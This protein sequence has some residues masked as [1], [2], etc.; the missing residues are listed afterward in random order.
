MTKTRPIFALL[1][2][3][4]FVPAF[5]AMNTPAHAQGYYDRGDYYDR[6]DGYRY[7][8][9]RWDD[10]NW[11]R[12]R[13]GPATYNP[14]TPGRSSGIDSNTRACDLPAYRMDPRCYDD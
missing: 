13:G 4:A 10:R 14:R 5:A 8:R 3:A 9:D 6:Y 12:E 2:A 11:R 7:D 1:A